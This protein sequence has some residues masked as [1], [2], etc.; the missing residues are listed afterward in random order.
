MRIKSL[1]HLC[2]LLLMGCAVTLFGFGQRCMAGSEEA[3]VVA[4]V[5]DAPIMQ[6]QLDSV[7]EAYKLQTRKKAID[8]EETMALLQ[9]LIRRQL[10]LQLDSVNAL[11]KDEAIE[12]KVKTYENSLI[13]AKFVEEKVGRKLKVSEEEVA[14]YYE[15][16]RY[17][18]SSPPKVEAS[19]ILLRDLETAQKVQEKL[20]KG[21][22]FAQLAKQ[23]SIDLPMALEGGE[24]G[25]IER[26]EALP[27]LEKVL[28]T[29]S[30]GETS[31]I[32]KTRFGYHILRVDKIIPV[33][34]TPLEEVSEQI[35]RVI[36]QQKEAKA[37]EEMTKALEKAAAIK[38][39]NDRLFPT[40]P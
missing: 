24:M 23:F 9:G 16:N 32:V 2:C 30:E 39:Y 36:L 12:R 38:I 6:S 21:E 28:F 3:S 40:E 26:G 33:S 19:H 29:L 20:E 8:R 10:I 4:K 37:F 34:F 31:E 22:D 17:K 15:E 18:F 27:E 25:T 1:G 14:K 7:I 13:V 11:R 5:N 35:K